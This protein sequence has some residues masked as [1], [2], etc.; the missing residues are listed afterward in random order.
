MLGADYKCLKG[1]EGKEFAASKTINE[2]LDIT[3]ATEENL[4]VRLSVASGSSSDVP[5]WRPESADQAQHPLHQGSGAPASGGWARQEAQ[6][7]RGDRR[8]AQDLSCACAAKG[9]CPCSKPGPVHA[10]QRQPAAHLQCYTC[11]HQRARVSDRQR[12]GVSAR[13]SAQARQGKSARRGA[14]RC[15]GERV[16]TPATPGAHAGCFTALSAGVTCGCWGE[17]CPRRGPAK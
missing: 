10:R 1:K 4:K 12:R 14:A 13:A 17:R 8:V 11:L 16:C 9:G 6:A 7:Q 5:A 15:C 2:L 3:G